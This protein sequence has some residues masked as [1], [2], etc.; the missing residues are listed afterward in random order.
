VAKNTSQFPHLFGLR[1]HSIF[2]CASCLRRSEPRAQQ[3]PAA[4][5]ARPLAKTIQDTRCWAKDSRTPQV[6][7]ATSPFLNQP[8]NTFSKICRIACR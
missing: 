1:K 5:G 2:A 8:A 6:C 3:C 7:A 4:N